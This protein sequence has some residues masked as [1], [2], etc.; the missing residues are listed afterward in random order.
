MIA[1][2]QS[3]FY[4]F[5]NLQTKN[6]VADYTG[7]EGDTCHFGSYDTL[8]VCAACEEFSRDAVHNPCPDGN[9]TSDDYYTLNE[10]ESEL[11]LVALNGILNITSDTKHPVAEPINRQTG[12]LIVRM[13]AIV[14]DKINKN[15]TGAGASAIEC[16]AWW[17]VQR[18]SAKIVNGTLHEKLEHEYTD[19]SESGRTKYLQE[20]DIVLTPPNCVINGSKSSNE[21]YC[22]FHAGA[23][24][25]AGLHN[26]LTGG[27]YPNFRPGFLKGSVT[28]HPHPT[29]DTWNSTTLLAGA[30]ATD[31]IQKQYFNNRVYQG[32][33]TMANFMSIRISETPSVW[34]PSVAGGYAFENTF[35]YATNAEQ[36]F[37][38]RWAWITYPVVV[39]ILSLLFLLATIWIT[40]DD[41]P[42]KS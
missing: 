12:P 17:C 7:C 32:F 23:A 40:R 37:D 3:G 20:H 2:I 25:Q 31:G 34:D 18:N 8:A 5:S 36:R 29:T 35:G 26:F 28:R 1:A 30:L 22:H 27:Q 24:T 13:M 33:V 21:S 16:A 14:A 39:V 6:N 10:G 11:S 38:V 42:W 41:E 15:V 19:T 9:C 4:S